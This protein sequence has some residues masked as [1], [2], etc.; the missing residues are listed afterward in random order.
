MK[1]EKTD[2]EV[3]NIRKT[4]SNKFCITNDKNETMNI[5]IVSYYSDDDIVGYENDETLYDD[6]QKEINWS[7]VEAFLG[8][9]DDIDEL[10]EQID[11]LIKN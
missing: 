9:N 11:E 6:N 3:L 7:D 10:R 8:E 1:I 5:D 2:Y 4:T